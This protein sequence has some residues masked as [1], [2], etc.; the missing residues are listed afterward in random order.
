M[1]KEPSL[2]LNSVIAAGS[3][4][5]VDGLVPWRIGDPAE[6]LTYLILAAT[7]ATFRFRLRGLP[8]N[9]SLAFLIILMGIA[10]LPLP[11]ALLIGSVAVLVEALWKPTIRQAASRV[12]LYLAACVISV[13]L[14]HDVSGLPS[15]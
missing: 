10:N 14:A 2:Y 5:F 13:V 3:V 1:S 8:A 12:L 4:M 15:I 11:Q 6:F 9:D 7:A